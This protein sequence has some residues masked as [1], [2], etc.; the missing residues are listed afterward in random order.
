MNNNELQQAYYEKINLRLND[1][2]S[3]KQ[4]DLL[5]EAMNY[6]VT[7]G[8]KR[9]RPI[10]VLAVNDIFGGDSD[11]AMTFGCAME[12]IHAYSLIFDD[13]PGMDNDDLRRGK[14]TN[15]KVFGVGNAML[16]GLGLYS[17]AYDII[18]ELS[19]KGKI[20]S[21]KCVEALKTVTD[22]SGLKGIIIGQFLDLKNTDNAVLSE[23]DINEINMGKTVAMIRGAVKLGCISGN[24]DSET[25]RILDDFAVNLGL[26]FQLRDDILDVVGDAKL[27]KTLG[28]DKAH[29]KVTLVDIYGLQNA[30][31]EV[32]RLSDAAINALEKIENTSFLQYLTRKLCNRDF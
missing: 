7:I 26:A 3:F 18:I 17:K 31:D 10:I 12:M 30:Q 8:G 23:D 28:K 25:A 22:A 21:D 11:V 32:I 19:E 24:S 29:G 5:G 14:P 2:L 27:G 6:G 4:N 15:H 1:Y 16:A 13:L 20:A 9:L